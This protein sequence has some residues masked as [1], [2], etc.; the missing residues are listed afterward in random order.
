MTPKNL[1]PYLTTAVL[2]CMLLACGK[3][4]AARPRRVP[5]RRPLAASH[6]RSSP[7][8]FTRS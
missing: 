6:R 4:E 1:T 3:E 7:T 5:L 2:G 8:V